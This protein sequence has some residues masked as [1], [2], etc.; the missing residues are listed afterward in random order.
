MHLMVVSLGE[1]N[2]RVVRP[3]YIHFATSQD[4]YFDYDFD[5]NTCLS[6]NLA[7][8]VYI[9]ITKKCFKEELGERRH[10][11]MLVKGRD[12]LEIGRFVCL[13]VN[14]VSV[15]HNQTLSNL[16]ANFVYYF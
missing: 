14:L 13:S 15:F 11:G 4:R 2:K 6:V 7:P 16:V 9:L 12:S 10:V 8:A 1:G 3:E 5:R